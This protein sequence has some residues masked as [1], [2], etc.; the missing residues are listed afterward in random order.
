MLGNLE[1]HRTNRGKDRRLV[2]SK[3]GAQHLNDTLVV[4]LLDTAP[5]LLVPAGVLGTRHPEVLWGEGWDRREGDRLVD[6]ES[7]THP[8]GVGVDQTHDI[9]RKGDVKARA[10]ATH[11]VLGVLGGERAVGPRVGDDHAPLKDP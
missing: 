1:L 6:V 3:I 8:K 11:D 2:T 9:T 7:V 4:K 10:F 5:E